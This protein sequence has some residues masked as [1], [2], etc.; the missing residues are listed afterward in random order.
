MATGSFSTPKDRKLPDESPVFTVGQPASADR[1]AWSWAFPPLRHTYP[2]R[3]SDAPSPHPQ[4]RTRRMPHVRFGQDPLRQTPPRGDLSFPGQ[5]R[6]PL[7]TTPKGLPSRARLTPETKSSHA[8]RVET[9]FFSQFSLLGG[10]NSGGKPL[11]PPP[12]LRCPPTSAALH[13][14]RTQ[15]AA[16]GPHTPRR[17]RAVKIRRP[18]PADMSPFGELPRQRNCRSTLA[19]NRQHRASVVA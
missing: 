13:D 7:T 19:P 5:E 3:T 18:S 6:L 4:F 11:E 16:S 15:P 2:D 8:F 12:P 17:V 10:F 14:P 9:W 1:D